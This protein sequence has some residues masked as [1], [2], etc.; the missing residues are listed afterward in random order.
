MPAITRIAGQILAFLRK[1]MKESTI[2]AVFTLCCT[3]GSFIYTWYSSSSFHKI[4]VIFQLYHCSRI[5]FLIVK[6][7]FKWK[8]WKMLTANQQRANGRQLVRITREASRSG[9][10]KDYALIEIFRYLSF[11]VSI[12]LFFIYREVFKTANI[13]LIYLT[14]LKVALF[15]YKLQT[16]LIWSLKF[17]QNVYNMKVGPKQYIIESNSR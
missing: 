6:M 17:K 9:L 3:L 13:S 11:F 16:R 10:I 14:L 15:L 2:I 7:Y 1:D 12:V 8:F 5:Y 4:D